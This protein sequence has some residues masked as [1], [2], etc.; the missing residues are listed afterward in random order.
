[1]TVS[2]ALAPAA[3][4]VNDAGEKL[5]A[6]E[7]ALVIPVMLSGALPVLDIVT[8]LDAVV[9]DRHVSE[10]QRRRRHT[11]NRLCNYCHS[12]SLLR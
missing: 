3:I 9:A 1:M 4:D 8:V 12:S 11:E 7:P 10:R 2:V 6:A 5:K